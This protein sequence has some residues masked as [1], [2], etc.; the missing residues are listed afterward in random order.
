MEV[1]FGTPAYDKAVSVDYNRS[2][3]GSAVL[4]T[5]LGVEVHNYLL[6]GNCFLGMARNAIAQA[7]LETRATDLLFID[8][9]V[10][11]DPQVLPR[12]LAYEEEIVG[13]LIPKRDTG[14]ESCFHQNAL[15]GVMQNG[16]FQSLE[17]P[18][19]FMR[20]KRSAFA[21]LKMPYFRTESSA[22]EY[23]E[24][25]Y[26]CRRWCETGGYLWIDADITFTHRGSK[27]WS[28]NFYEHCVRTGV[29]KVNGAAA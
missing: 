16:L 11:W 18:T 19:A 8:A 6:A 23:G 26:F 14:S 17:L 25:I 9:D 28:G 27:A 20:I 13:G 4:L 29:L 1:F 5:K 7:F 12:I 22:E 2:L 3:V 10:G 21:K 24:D 15:T